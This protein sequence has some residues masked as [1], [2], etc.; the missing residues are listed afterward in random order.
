MRC[1]RDQAG[2]TV[3]NQL[4]AVS[5]ESQTE[6]IENGS[7]LWP[8]ALRRRLNSARDQ[9]ERN[10]PRSSPFRRTS[11]RPGLKYINSFEFLEFS[12]ARHGLSSAETESSS[13]TPNRRE[14]IERYGW[15]TLVAAPLLLFASKA[16]AMHSKPRREAAEDGK[17][18]TERIL[19]ATAAMRPPDLCCATWV[20]ARPRR[21]LS[22]QGGIS[23]AGR[24]YPSPFSF[25]HEGNPSYRMRL[26]HGR[27]WE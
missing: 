17:T 8:P 21:F 26:G 18:V 12:A 7:E 27:S 3:T 22:A 10:R 5:S 23:T 13:E 20:Y 16:H 15:C 11:F 6:L 14:L 1:A 24:F 2:K 9:Q 25:G 19:D 4:S